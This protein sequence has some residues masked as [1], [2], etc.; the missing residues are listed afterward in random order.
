MS[1]EN[2]PVA[3]VGSP[4][5]NAELVLDIV[6]DAS[7]T[8]LIGQMVFVQQDITTPDG[9]TETEL[10]VGTVSEITTTNQWHTN[11]ALLGII[12]DSGYLAGMTGDPGDLRQARVRLQSTFRQIETD[13][14]WRPAG[15][16]LATSPAT[17]TRTHLL[18]DH[19]IQNVVVASSPEP[20][21][22]LGNL[23]GPA[24]R[25]GKVRVPFTI[26]NYE[27]SR[28]G[29]SGAIFG[30]TGSGKTAQAAYILASQMRHESMGFIII[31][32]QGQFAHERGLPFSL[33]GWAEELG[34]PVSVHRISE[35]LRLEKDAPLFCL[36]LSK[37]K[38]I[39][40]LTKMGGDTAE[41][42]LDEI[43]KHLKKV[44]GWE[45][46]DSP[47]LL[48]SAM[49]YLTQ[50]ST[51][52]RIYADPMRQSRL[53]EAITEIL[54]D[55]ERQKEVLEYFSVI[56]NLFSRRNPAGK[57]RNSLWSILSSV[58]ATEQRTGKAPLVILDMSISDISWMDAFSD[59]Q[60]ADAE[61]AIR[62]LDSDTIKAAILNQILSTMRRTAESNYRNGQGLNTCIVVD[63]A[64]RY[65]PNPNTTDDPEIA[66]LAN[67]FSAAARDF[68]K[69]QIGLW[70][71]S[72]AARSLHPDIYDQLLIRVVG[73]GLAGADLDKIAE[74]LEDRDPLKLY[75]S[76]VPP[77]STPK[78]ARIYPFMWQGPV[79]P[80]AVTRAPIMTA[81]YTDF[82]HFRTDNTPWIKEIRDRMGAP[83]MSG[84]PTPLGAGTAAA[85]SLAGKSRAAKKKTAQQIATVVEHKNTGGIP[86]AA[87]QGLPHSPEGYGDPLADLDNHPPP[88]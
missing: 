23:L 19:T 10:A 80:L 46:M 73:Y 52:N 85:A 82:D 44:D 74:Q 70:L 12:R 33:Q 43:E 22:Y 62:L 32:P 53:V 16:G 38:F 39:R 71:V 18:D 60:R 68:R 36:L 31:D 49:T 56:H 14:R 6:T 21:H 4:S 88:F 34:R 77:D 7:H 55:Q 84:P 64:W 2:T 30:N 54:D 1:T 13:E 26:P 69:L 29:W 8:P 37:T 27:G 35:D 87:A 28:G 66:Q 48:T 50:E 45:D 59:Q 79:S 9:V 41:I 25:G 78:D 5:T 65:A 76:F 11:P 3:V 72:Q 24:T 42:V 81:A 67:T 63:E 86:P 58:F 47:A 75:R 51:L 40:S 15:A 57:P 61:E 20:V 83:V 17:G